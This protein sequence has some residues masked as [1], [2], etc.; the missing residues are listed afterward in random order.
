MGGM[1]DVTPLR[2]I[3]GANFRKLRFGIMGVLLSP[4]S[5]K[6]A[7]VSGTARS[8]PP[9]ALRIYGQQA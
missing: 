4:K 2:V 1:G 5:S 3:D 7:C 8:D 6:T 9:M